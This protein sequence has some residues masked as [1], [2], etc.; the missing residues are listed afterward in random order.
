[1]IIIIIPVVIKP[2]VCGEEERGDEESGGDAEGRGG[3][4][5]TRRVQERPGGVRDQIAGGG[6]LVVRSI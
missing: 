3:V 1:M 5:E 2:M 4:R 6:F